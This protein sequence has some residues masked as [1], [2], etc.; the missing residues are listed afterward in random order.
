VLTR[1]TSDGINLAAFGLDWR[2][3]DEVVLSDQE[4]PSGALPWLV[5]ARRLGARV[6]VAP[7]ADDPAETLQRFADHITPRTRLVFA[8]HVT[9]LRGLR[10]PVAGICELA[11]RAGALAVV[12]GA[13]AVGQFAVAPR[14]IGADVYVTSGHKWLLGPQGA[15]FAYIARERLEAIQPSWIG[16]GAQTDYTLAGPQAG[17]R[18]LD[19]A[20]RYEFGTR[21][22]PVFPGL[23]RAIRLIRDE[24]TLP[25]IEARVRGLAARLK[26]DLDNLPGAERL[27][28]TEPE[29]CAGAVCVRLAG[30]PADLK[31]L[32]WERHRVI[33]AYDAEARCL[34]LSVAWFTTEAELEAALAAIADCAG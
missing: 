12:D 20:R 1:N 4:H 16:W 31:E 22:W 2:P 24:A 25:A 23:A 19:S 13:H 30:A 29:R 7:A 34:R 6:C 26:A 11:Q 14:A 8:S 10:L 32:L 5:L 21:H 18:L 27:T 15:S 28:P 17:L 9:S 3:G 33:A